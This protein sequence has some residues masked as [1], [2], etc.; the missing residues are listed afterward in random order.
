VVVIQKRSCIG[1]LACVGFCDI[2][3]M[4]THPD[5]VEPFKCV[6]CGRCVEACPENALS[7]QNRAE[8][9][10]SETAK[11]TERMKAR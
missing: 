8:M 7:V 1:C 5:Y 6:A 4:R 9:D 3:A 11:W 10:L 2:W